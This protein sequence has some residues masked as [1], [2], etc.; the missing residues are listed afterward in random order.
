ILDLR[1]RHLMKLEE[2]KI[3]GEQ[4]QL[5][6]ERE[7]LEATLG[8]NAKLKR[9]IADELTADAKKYGDERRSELIERPQAQALSAADLMPSEAITV[10]LSRQGWIRAAKGQEID[11]EK[12]NFRN[13]DGYLASASGRSN[14]TLV[15]L[16][17]TGR[18]YTLAAHKLPSARGQGEPLTSSVNPPDGARFVGLALGGEQ[19]QCVLLSTA[20][21]GFVSRLGELASRNRRGKAVLTVP[22]QAAALGLFPV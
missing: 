21:Y 10:V 17:A 7:T 4:E 22:K 12:L 20:G 15:V 13:G 18:S 9:L 14:Q 19:L 1:L 3:R 6:A 8:S 16:G 11:A 2:M 5:E